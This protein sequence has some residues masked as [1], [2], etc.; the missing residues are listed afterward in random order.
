MLLVIIRQASQGHKERKKVK[1]P[2][3]NALIDN[4]LKMKIINRIK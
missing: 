3:L 4:Q 2:L 1:Y